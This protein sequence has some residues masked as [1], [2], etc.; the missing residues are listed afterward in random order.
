MKVAVRPRGI[1]MDQAILEILV[2]IIGTGIVALIAT[3]I[4]SVIV[5]N[6]HQVI[7]ENHEER[8]KEVEAG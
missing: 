8:I 6:K 1:E 3:V 5:Q 4:R 2:Y 7:L